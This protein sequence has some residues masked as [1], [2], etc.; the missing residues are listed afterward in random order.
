MESRVRSMYNQLK[1]LKTKLNTLCSDLDQVLYDY[2][3]QW[4]DSWTDLKTEELRKQHLQQQ[5][6]YPTLEQLYY[7]RQA[8]LERYCVEYEQAHG[9]QPINELAEDEID[10]REWINQL[11]VRQQHLINVILYWATWWCSSTSTSLERSGWIHYVF[12]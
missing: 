9:I 10:S 7:K 5:R 11:T 1:D 2:S 12:T 3:E 4:P 6:T 8:A